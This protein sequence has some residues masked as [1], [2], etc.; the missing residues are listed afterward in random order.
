MR[1]LVA[2]VTMSS[3]AAQTSIVPNGHTNTEGGTNNTIP[4]W[5]VSNT[6]QQIHD[7]A[8]VAAATG[9]ATP[10]ISQISFRKDGQLTSGLTGRSLEA[11]ISLGIT[12]VSPISMTTT[13]AT[14][15]GPTPTVVL[16]YT[17]INLPSLSNTGLPN[18]QGWFF[19][20]ATPYT[21]ATAMGHLCWE[22]RHKNATLSSTAPC[23]AWSPNNSI[24]Y[25]NLGLGCVATGQTLP[26]QIGTRSLTITTGAYRNML[27]RAAASAPAVFFLGVA[28][29]Q[30]SLPGLCSS[31]E[32]IPIADVPG[33][34]DAA[35]VWDLTITFGS[36]V[37]RGAANIY[38]Q[39]AFVDANLPPWSIGLSNATWMA[40]PPGGPGLSSRC[41]AAGS[42]AGVGFET[43]L[44]GTVGLNYGLITGFN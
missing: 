23:D 42:N 29:Q 1:L 6:Y 38:G 24:V 32:F 25:P 37:G 5:N 10:V 27:S 44:T 33:G 11:E 3:L 40:T 12:T 18:P 36:L 16:P 2:L 9:S 14:N 34:T 22:L 7:S 21:Y 26:A 41:W 30:I 13:F 15:I 43:A 4:W 20:F 17:V 35:G 28:P 19:P 39:F 31:L 8:D